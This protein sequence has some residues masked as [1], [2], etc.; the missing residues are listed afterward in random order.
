[1]RFEDLLAWQKVRELTNGVYRL[2]QNK[3]LA[4]D[5]GLRDQIQRAAVSAMNNIAEGFERQ[6]KQ[7][8]WHFYNIA[9]GSAGEVRSLTYVVL[10]INLAPPDSVLSVQNLA[11]ETGASYTASCVRQNLLN[12]EYSRFFLPPNP[13]SYIRSLFSS[14]PGFSSPEC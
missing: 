3:P 1:M 12:P 14:F 8:K 13:Q 2:C 11:S 6:G 5:L 10:D 4:I 7:E 9:K